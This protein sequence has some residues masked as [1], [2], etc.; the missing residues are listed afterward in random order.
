[1]AHFCHSFTLGKL[2]LETLASVQ[3]NWIWITTFLLLN[4]KVTGKNVAFLQ[5]TFLFC[6]YFDYPEL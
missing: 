5:N 4:L 1:M 2:S 3:F 6:V